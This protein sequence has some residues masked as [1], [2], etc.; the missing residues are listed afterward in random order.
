MTVTQELGGVMAIGSVR[1]I[2][3]GINSVFHRT[4]EIENP[5]RREL[6]PEP[7]SNPLPDF[8]AT[9]IAGPHGAV[10]LDTPPRE[11][12]PAPQ[13]APTATVGTPQKLDT[14]ELPDQPVGPVGVW[15]S[16]DPASPP[17]PSGGID[18][19]A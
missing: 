6:Q 14:P 17:A 2:F 8:P 1:G 12:V 15:V 3:S 16:N 9:H 5:P 7:I 4:H 13:P 19:V 10:H 18:V 11:D